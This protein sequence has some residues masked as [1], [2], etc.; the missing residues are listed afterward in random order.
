MKRTSW[1]ALFL[2]VASIA[3]AELIPDTISLSWSRGDVSGMNTSK[4][5]LAGM[6]YRI[7]GMAYVNGTNAQD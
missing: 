7:E 3:Q 6:T 4:Y 2:L 1:I 5:P